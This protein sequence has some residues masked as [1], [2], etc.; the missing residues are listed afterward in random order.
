MCVCV[1]LNHYLM[2]LDSSSLASG[3]MLSH[4]YRPEGLIDAT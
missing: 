3:H 1:S 4:T 2:H